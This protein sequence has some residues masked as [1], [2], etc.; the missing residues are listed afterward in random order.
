MLQ[1]LQAASPGD[2]VLIHAAAT[3]TAPPQRRAMACSGGTLERRGGAFWTWPIRD[4]AP[5]SMKMPPV[6]MVVERVPEA[7][8]AYLFQNLGLY[9]ERV[10]GLIVISENAPADA[11]QSHMLHIAR[12]IYSMPR[13]M[14]LRLPQKIF[15]DRSSSASGSKNSIHAHADSEMRTLL[16][17]DFEMRR[18]QLVRFLRSSTACFAARRVARSGG[19]AAREASHL[20]DGG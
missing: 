15:A 6:R 16:R 10:G 9:R 1:R 12:S 2:A 17:K 20:H 8:I 11:V 18:R 3:T 4:S 7:L 19:T 14:A 5:R 13:I